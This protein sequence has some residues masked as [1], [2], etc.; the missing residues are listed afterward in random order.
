[1]MGGA[2]SSLWRLGG[3]TLLV[4]AMLLALIRCD[5][6]EPIPAEALVVE[7]FLE[8][9][10]PLPD[11]L[12]RESRDLNNPGTGTQ[13]GATGA[14]VWLRLGSDSVAYAA[15]P[16]A[17]GRYEPLSGPDTVPPHVAFQLNVRWN[18]VR[19]TATGTTP[20]RIEL[21]EVCLDV[22]DAPVEAIL[23][24]SVRRDSLD[25]PAEQ[26]FL[27]PIDVRLTWDGSPIPADTAHWVRGQLHPSTSL[28]SGGR[29]VDFFLQPAVVKREADFRIADGRHRW[30]GV[31]AVPVDS[32]TAPLPPHTLTSDVVRGDGAFG[33]FATSRTDPDR[34]APTSNVSGALGIATGIALDSL[35]HEVT[36]TGVHCISGSRIS[37]SRISGS[38]ADGD[39]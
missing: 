23:V 3:R 38:G 19:A 8:T 32:A 13:D 12:L 6:T 20:P 14:R 9:G 7:M 4:L 35:Q 37:G 25:I 2:Y 33:S 15:N 10:K 30:R 22:P 1:M 28:Q 11:V 36:R 34:R 24:D 27:Y 39:R 21:R 29:V 31:Y 18:G 16:D 17:P 5:V 26:G